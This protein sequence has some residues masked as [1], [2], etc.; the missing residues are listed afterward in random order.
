MDW[1]TIAGIVATVAIGAIVLWALIRDF[2]QWGG[3]K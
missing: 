1:T 3:D 2:D